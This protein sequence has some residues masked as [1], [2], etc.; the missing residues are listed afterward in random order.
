MMYMAIVVSCI[1]FDVHCMQEEKVEGQ[2]T[3][4]LFP[5]STYSFTGFGD[6]PT[7]YGN[8][9][10]TL[11]GFC[12]EKN[13]IELISGLSKTAQGSNGITYTPETIMQA[14]ETKEIRGYPLSWHKK[15][16]LNGRESLVIV[17]ESERGI[18]ERI[19]MSRH[20]TKRLLRYLSY[21]ITENHRNSFDL[22]QEVAF[23][24][25][26]PGEQVN[27][28]ESLMN[29]IDC[30]I[31]VKNLKSGDVIGLY[32]V[33]QLNDHNNSGSLKFKKF[34]IFLA[35]DMYLAKLLGEMLYVSNLQSL[36][37]F[38]QCNEH[39][40]IDPAIGK[41]SGIANYIFSPITYRNVIMTIYLDEKCEM[42]C[43]TSNLIC[44][45]FFTWLFGLRCCK[46][47]IQLRSDA[48]TSGAIQSFRYNNTQELLNLLDKGCVSTFPL[49]CLK[50]VRFLVGDELLTISIRQNYDDDGQAAYLPSQIK[51]RLLAYL[52]YD[53]E[54]ESRQC[55]DFCYEVGLNKYDDKDKF[56][57]EISYLSK[58]KNIKEDDLQPGNVVALG[59]GHAIKHWAMALGIMGL[60]ISKA[61]NGG[62]LVVTTMQNMKS[63][64]N[65]KG[66]VLI[67]PT[68]T[69]YSLFWKHW[70]YDFVKTLVRFKR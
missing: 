45:T 67:K 51:K 43:T 66:F 39:A 40:K 64:W 23:E 56:I 15:V 17:S 20:I 22:C 70:Q 13:K 50:E 21:D 30:A 32:Q 44:D 37:D 6:R 52:L 55:F 48:V 1:F 31:P 42:R 12:C 28:D 60:Y 3:L 8:I 63:L 61:G 47:G 26:L 4:R 9:T 59:T 25:S 49:S 11:F 54:D 29:Y 27:E 10:A 57:S 18:Q 34:V 33:K 68:I 62:P 53:S 69:Q 58:W 5:F 38:W 65:C 46:K 14:L 35:D 24:R 7:V 2:I 36:K 16:Y 41:R 19:N